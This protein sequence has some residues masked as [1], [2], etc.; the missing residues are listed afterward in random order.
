M[1]KMLETLLGQPA[2]A[3]ARISA[4]KT[5][6]VARDPPLG[7]CASVVLHV[8]KL[9]LT[10]ISVHKRVGHHREQFGSLAPPRSPVE[11][12]RREFSYSGA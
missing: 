12:S 4:G 1:V 6:P 11:I 8:A 5:R 10:G 7:L 9:L 3:V 2:V